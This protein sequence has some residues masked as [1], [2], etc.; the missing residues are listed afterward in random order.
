MNKELREKVWK[1]Y[2]GKCAYCGEDLAYKNMQVD[3]IEAKHSNGKD[4]FEN[5]NPSCR[6]CNFYKGTNTLRIFRLDLSTITDRIK[7]P[8]IVRLAM[9]YNLI[10]FKPFDGK[11][12]FEKIKASEVCKFNQHIDVC[13]RK[14]DTCFECVK[15]II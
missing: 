8:F 10:Q 2:N 13:V 15:H 5:Y 6:Q 11:F 1:K 12:Y 9:K 14:Y 4:E 3:H 7:K